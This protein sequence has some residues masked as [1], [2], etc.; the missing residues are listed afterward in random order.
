MIVMKQSPKPYVYVRA[1]VDGEVEEEALI[2]FKKDLFD[3]M[4]HY[5]CNYATDDT[6][7]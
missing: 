5:W 4:G 1:L 3:K 6:V 7:L 2:Q